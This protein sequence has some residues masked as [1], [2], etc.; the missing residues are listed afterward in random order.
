MPDVHS[1]GTGMCK[2]NDI[3]TFFFSYISCNRQYLIRETINSH[4]FYVRSIV[5]EAIHRK[6]LRCLCKGVTSCC[7][8]VPFSNTANVT[9]ESFLY[10]GCDDLPCQ[11][12]SS[13]L[14]PSNY[15]QFGTPRRYLFGKDIFLIIILTRFFFCFFLYCKNENLKETTLDYTVTV[16]KHFT[17]KTGT[18]L[19]LQQ[20]HLRGTSSWINVV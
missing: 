5:Q 4:K 9:K 18:T 1:R 20:R 19:T 14:A 17:H 12:Q 11:L 16:V 3:G 6:R 7:T 15:H 10:Y 8:T 2:Q 13:K